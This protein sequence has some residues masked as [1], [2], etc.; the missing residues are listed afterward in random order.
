MGKWSLRDFKFN[1]NLYVHS[2]KSHAA[3]ILNATILLIL[4]FIHEF[5]L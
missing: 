5:I 1:F 4:T 2:E 3:D